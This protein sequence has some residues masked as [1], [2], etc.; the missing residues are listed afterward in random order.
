M[1]SLYAA[2][3]LAMTFSHASARA[4][5]LTSAEQATFEQQLRSLL[6]RSD[7]TASQQYHHAYNRL[8]FGQQHNRNFAWDA[9]RPN[10][11]RALAQEIANSL[12]G[13]NHQRRNRDDPLV[14]IEDPTRNSPFSSFPYRFAKTTIHE[15]YTE[16]RQSVEAIKAKQAELNATTDAAARTALQAE[17]RL[18]KRV[19][20]RINRDLQETPQARLVS[21]LTSAPNIALPEVLSEFWLNHFNVDARKA[22]WAAVD[23]QKTLRRHHCGTFYQL[24]KA[25]AQHPAMLI[26]LDNFRSRRG[27][28]NENYGRELLELHTLGDDTFRFYQQSDVV[29]AAEVLTGWGIRFTQLMDDSWDARFHFYA[30]GH[31]KGRR[32]LFDTAPNGTPL[33]LPAIVNGQ[34]NA[35]AQAVKR[36]EDLLFYLAGHISTRRNICRKLSKWILGHAP[37]SLV[38]SCADD[39]VWGTNGGDLPAVYRHIL[40]H[41]TMFHSVT[42]LPMDQQNSVRNLYQSKQKNPLQLVVSAYRT[43]AQPHHRIFELDQIRAQIRVASK[44][45][46]SPAHYPPPTGYP[47]NIA[48]LTPGLLLTYNAFLYQQIGTDDLRLTVNNEVLKG[49]RLEA[50]VRGRLG[51][52]PA[53]TPWVDIRAQLNALTSELIGGAVKQPWFQNQINRGFRNALLSPDLE[54]VNNA[55]KP[56]RTFLHLY[57]GHSVSIRK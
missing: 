27:R 31:V 19:R 4:Q 55:E 28:L 15:A 13:A 2:T 16:F 11:R 42:D 54:T 6:N 1:R 9:S 12:K 56:F 7:W 14:L 44:M 43:S 40:T 21:M 5:C 10:K 50:Y 37:N 48:W 30:S 34:N 46:I 45:G 57:L 32:T 20:N 23:Y 47:D 29:K 53:G 18:L 26:Y 33:V 24:L 17:I 49:N 8:G 52:I 38:N 22:K 3:L 39:A 25:S 35:T 51:A 41:R 36:G